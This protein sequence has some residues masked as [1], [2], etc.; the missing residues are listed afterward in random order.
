MP[1]QLQTISGKLLVTITIALTMLVVGFTTFM[2][3]RV[4]S[5]VKERVLE[6]STLR[7]SEISQRVGAQLPE[8]TSAATALGGALSGFLGLDFP[9]ARWGAGR[10]RSEQGGRGRRDLDDGGVEGGFVGLRR[11][12]EAAELANQL[13]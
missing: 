2:A 12:G 5:E 10:Q 9:I 1:A 4:S 8:A 3:W 13:Q 7:A 6:Q 11:L